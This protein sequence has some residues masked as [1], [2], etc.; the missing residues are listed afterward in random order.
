[1]KFQ[2]PQPQRSVKVVLDHSAESSDQRQYSHENGFSSINSNVFVQNLDE[3]LTLDHF[4]STLGFAPGSTIHD[5][6]CAMTQLL[7]Q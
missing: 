6:K 2:A 5:T 7:M 4:D 3:R 1:M